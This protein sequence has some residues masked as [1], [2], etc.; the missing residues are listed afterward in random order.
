MYSTI[1][2]Y[3]KQFTFRMVREHILIFKL[4]SILLSDLIPGYTS[5]RGMHEL[6]FPPVYSSVLNIT[7]LPALPRKLVPPP[8]IEECT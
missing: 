5:G 4:N 7:N 1:Q 3:L 6:E 2:T 8:C